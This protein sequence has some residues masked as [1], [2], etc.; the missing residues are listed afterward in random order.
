MAH[1][2]QMYIGTREQMNWVEAPDA[3]SF[4]NSSVG[5]ASQQNYL[6]GGVRIRRSKSTHREY[7]MTWTLI[8]QDDARAITDM[9]WGLYGS[10]PIYFLD[11]M[12]MATNLAPAHWA[13]PMMGAAEAPLLIKGAKPVLSDT[14]TLNNIGY[15]IKTATY[16]TGEKRKLYIPLPDTHTLWVG[17]HGPVTGGSIVAAG[18]LSPTNVS[19]GVVLPMLGTNTTTRVNTAFDGATYKGVEFTLQDGASYTGLIIQVL[20]TGA[21]P[22]TGGFISG[23]GHSGT[24]FAS[25][26]AT[27]PYRAAL[28]LVGVSMELK[29][30]NDWL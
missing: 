14:S 17:V 6:N 27:S 25:A 2:R 18:A 16:G 22:A 20:P 8:S 24:E 12:A 1:E 3:S 7:T 30:T 5:W 19:A 23:Q 28:G 15:P 13:A 9:Y 21:T 10:G 4:T 26:P 29:E 11:P